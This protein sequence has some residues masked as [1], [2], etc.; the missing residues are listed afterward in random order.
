MFEFKYKGQVIKFKGYGDKYQ[1]M[2]EA[3]KM[4]DLPEGGWFENHFEPGK[5][6]WVEGNFFD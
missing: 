4:F 1:A 6:E 2:V 5:F 3:N